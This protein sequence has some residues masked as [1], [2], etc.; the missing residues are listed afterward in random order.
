M[1]GLKGEKQNEFDIKQGASEAADQ[2]E[3]H[4]RW[5]DYWWWYRQLNSGPTDVQNR[6][7]IV[8]VGCDQDDNENAAV[9][10]YKQ[11]AI[12]MAQMKSR[13]TE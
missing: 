12:N 8:G 5:R 11:L 7:A 13:Q 4:D 6:I 10:R 2:Q 1:K 3:G 9:V